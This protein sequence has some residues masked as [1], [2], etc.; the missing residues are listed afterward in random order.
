MMTGESIV[1]KLSKQGWRTVSIRGSHNK[2]E[3][4]TGKIVVIPCHKKDLPKGT[5]NAI[6]KQTGLK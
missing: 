1:K 5:L 6:L 2:M 4:A 3:S